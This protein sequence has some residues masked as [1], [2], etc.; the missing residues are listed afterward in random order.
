MT[1][2]PT[3]MLEHLRATQCAICGTP[4]A[5]EELYPANL[6]PEAFTPAVFSAR[7]L[8]DGTHYRMVRCGQCGLV[9]SDPVL[10]ADAL[11][12]LYR[13]SSFDYGEELEGLRATYGAALDR[14][15][16]HLSSRQGLLDVGCGSGFVLEVA[17]ERGWTDV[18]GVEPS[19]DAIAKAAPPVAPLIV[20]DMMRAGVF[21]DGSLSLVTLFQVLDH[22]PDPAG[23]LRD[24]RRILRPGGAILAFNH[25]VT[26]WSAR[27]LGERSPIIDVE[28][29]FLYSPE[30]MRRL[31]SEAGF[32]V[33]SVSPV[34]NTY[35]LAYLTHLVPLPRALKQWL[36]PR[37]R[38]TTLG[39][40]K[41]T[42]PLGNLCL[43]ARR[44]A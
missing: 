18:R 26:A 31:F 20:Q 24:C 42:V 30:T 39:R 37:L 16:G 23:L 29:T 3:T 14:A 9:R 19:G 10:G 33:L 43:I 21:D 32:D 35:S 17:Q 11:A 25:N 36:I 38:A 34:R 28:H 27:L 15:A 1:P 44:G 13:E 2:S 41:L 22:M 5:S 4:T 6:D 12:E 40:R 8:P 7:R